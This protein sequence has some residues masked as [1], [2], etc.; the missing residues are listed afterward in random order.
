MQIDY[1]MRTDEPGMEEVYTIIPDDMRMNPKCP[2]Q[3]KTCPNHGFCQYCVPHHRRLDIKLV[4]LGLGA[5]PQA[6]KRDH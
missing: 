2:C 3:A 4:E 5:H 6:C 1:G